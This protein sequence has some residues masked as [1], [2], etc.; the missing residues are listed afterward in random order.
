[1]NIVFRNKGFT[2]VE[3]LIVVVVIAILASITVVAYQGIQKQTINA[4]HYDEAQKWK[5]LFMAYAAQ[6]G[7]YPNFPSRKF[8]LGVGF[9]AGTNGEARCQNY[10]DANLYTY[11]A[12]TGGINIL[13]S[14]SDSLNT[15]LATITKTLP[16]S[17]RSVVG[18]IVGPWIMYYGAQAGGRIYQTFYNNQPCPDTMD[19]EYAGTIMNVCS[20]A[21][22]TI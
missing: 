17:D 2:I 12:N 6:N 4:S 21:L 13:A 16:K 14:D 10:K 20:I 5:T 1:M 8:C 3:L 19:L 9:P 15:E 7:Q 22:P 18:N 11:P